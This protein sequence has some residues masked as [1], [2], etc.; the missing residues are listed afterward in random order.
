[1]GLQKYS[2]EIELLRLRGNELLRTDLQGGNQACLEN[3][4]QAANIQSGASEWYR[5]FSRLRRFVS[6]RLGTFAL[7]FSAHP[8]SARNSHSTSCIERAR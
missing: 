5:S 4:F 3:Q 1:M 7:I 8:Y 6:A 2:W